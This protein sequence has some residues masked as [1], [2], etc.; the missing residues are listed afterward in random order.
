MPFADWA[1]DPAVN[2]A[3]ESL[4]RL[5][6]FRRD[7]S[8]QLDG[9]TDRLPTS[10]ARRRILSEGGTVSVPLEKLFRGVTPGE[11]VGPYLSQFLLI[12]NTGIANAQPI[13]DGMIAY[14]AIRANQRV[15]VAAENKD[16]MQTWNEWL[17]V[18][19]G[20]D[21]HGREIYASGYRFMATPRDLAT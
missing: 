17:D 2:G 5:W 16:Y 6:W 8:L 1:S 14:G 20:A 9:A 15:R 7:K 18:Q 12:G 4:K 10:L 11:Q 3:R 13:D 21:L 19:N